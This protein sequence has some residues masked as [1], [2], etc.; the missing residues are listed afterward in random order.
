MNLAQTEDGRIVIYDLMRRFAHN[1]APMYRPG[2]DG[3]ALAFKEGQRS[4][5]VYIGSQLEADLQ[6]LALLDAQQE[7]GE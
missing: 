1:L 2:D 4:V 7:T 3:M 6:Q 5:L